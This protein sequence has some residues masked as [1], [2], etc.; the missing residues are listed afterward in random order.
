MNYQE[1]FTAGLQIKQEKKTGKK[2]EKNR[3]EKQKEKIR[4]DSNPLAALGSG[5]FENRRSWH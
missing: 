2:Q 3:K 5:M 1:I 4:K